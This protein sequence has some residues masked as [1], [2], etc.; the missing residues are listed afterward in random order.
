[1]IP[2]NL[3]VLL[4]AKVIP[5]SQDIQVMTTGALRRQSFPWSR[6]AVGSRQMPFRPKDK[7]LLE[8]TNQR[9]AMSLERQKGVTRSP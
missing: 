5:D 2:T 3:P 8:Q 4:E 1:V 7:D 9:R 6:P